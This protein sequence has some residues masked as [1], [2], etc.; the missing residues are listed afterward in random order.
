MSNSC[1]KVIPRPPACFDGT[2]AD[3]FDEHMRKVLPSAVSVAAFHSQLTK[4]LESPTP[5]CLTRFIS[6]Q[7]RGHE[8]TINGVRCKPTDNAPAWWIHNSLF[9]GE[10][11][12]WNSFESAVA[13]TP[14]H[15]FSVNGRLP[16]SISEAGWHVAHIFTA[17]D[18]DTHTEN[19]NLKVRFVRNI[20]PC[21]YFYV[22]KSSW[23]KFG[24]A[25]GIIGYVVSRYREIYGDVWDDFLNHA[26]AEYPNTGESNAAHPITC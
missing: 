10:Q 2:I 5:L 22:P 11:D 8:I 15:F 17:K 23:R 12:R 13:D 6:G 14:C 16:K 26:S 7:K 9:Q 18:G 3:F 20:H 24:G 25:P 21:N 19:W 1:V 4:Y